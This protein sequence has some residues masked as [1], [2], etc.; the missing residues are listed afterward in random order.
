MKKQLL[1]K[2]LLMAAALFVGTSSVLA[3]PTILYERGT[4]NNWSNDD[5]TDW[6]ASATNDY[7]TYAIVS[8][9]KLENTSASTNFKSSYYATKIIAPTAKSIVTLSATITMGAATGRSSSYDYIKIAG[10]ELRVFGQDKK[11]QVYVDGTAQGSL[12]DAVRNGSYVINVTIDQVTNDVTYSV[13]GSSTI[14]EAKTT[15]NTA[16]TNVVIGHSRGGSE[17]YNS[18]LILTKIEISEEAQAVSTAGYTVKYVCGG[19]EIKD[20]DISRSGVIGKTVTLTE[21]DKAS[22]K[23]N[24]GTKKYIY[25]S[26]DSGSNAIEGD[27]STIITV[28]FREAETWSYTVNAMN[29]N[30]KIAEIFNGSNFEEENVTVPFLYYYNIN[31]TLYKKDPINKEYNYTF[32]LSSDNQVE[33]LAYTASSF[34]NVIFLS[35]A[36][37]IATLTAVT[38]GGVG[39]RCSKASGA[40]ADADALITTLTPGKYKLTG[41]GYG[42]N[43]IF[44][45]GAT[46][47]LNMAEAGYQREETSEEFEINTNT[48]ITFIGG[49]NN[50]AALDYVFIQQTG[51][52]VTIA[53]TGSSFASTFAI[54]CANLPANVTAYKVSA[55]AGGKATL[56]EV[57]EAVAPGTGLILIADAAGSYDIPVAATGNDISATNKL[58]GVTTATAIAAD[59][60]YGLKNGKF[61][62]LNAGTIPAGKAYLPAAVSAPE[63]DIVFDG[64]TTGISA[65]L[66]NSE[67][68]NSDVYDLQGRKVMNPT[69]GLY[70]VNGKK[71]AVK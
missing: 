68:V 12:V 37:D 49:T 22:F 31:G 41:A 18:A 64:N 6:T 7:L 34:N 10:T 57:T 8:G 54:D 3:T 9:L 66:V 63:L 19:A 25:V 17:N 24:G 45:A 1:T 20:A 67:K 43:L 30:S 56:T 39:A 11:A 55:V 62:K 16:I 71:F 2:M 61:V 36:E 46:E 42:G 21:S 53:A 52:P 27:G 65:T 4:T 32:T 51:I 35:E 38:G 23:N 70:I 29:G 28:T 14:A 60:A 44:K 69:K 13:S 33:E 5:L 48:D 58:V 26:D 47:I 40:F 59:A 50:N 15:S